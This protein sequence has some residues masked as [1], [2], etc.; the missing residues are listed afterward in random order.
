[1]SQYLSTLGYIEFFLCDGQGADGQAILYADSSYSSR[2]TKK[3]LGKNKQI[4]AGMKQNILTVCTTRYRDFPHGVCYS[5][6]STD[7]KFDVQSML[8][9]L[10][11][12][13]PREDWE[14]MRK[15][16]QWSEVDL[17]DNRY[18]QIIH[19]VSAANGAEDFYTCHGH[20]TRHEDLGVAMHLDEIT[21]QV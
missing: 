19:M 2:T 12:D 20:K 3:G 21:A 16:N 18:N 13:L 10:N 11:L 9:S 1:M 4:M 5:V 8:I 17:R 6:V 7:L 15:E 14:R